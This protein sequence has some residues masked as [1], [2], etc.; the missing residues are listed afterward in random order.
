MLL[1]FPPLPVLPPRSKER[2]FSKE[3]AHPL[4]GVPGRSKSPISFGAKDSWDKTF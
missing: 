4:R 1:P 3:V 2:N